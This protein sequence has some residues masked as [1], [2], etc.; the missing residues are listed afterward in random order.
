LECSV[1]RLPYQ[2]S[3]LCPNSRFDARLEKSQ[4]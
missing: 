1:C 4:F 3:A 2:I